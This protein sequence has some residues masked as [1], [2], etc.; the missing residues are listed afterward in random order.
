MDTLGET[1]GYNERQRVYHR[2]HGPPSHAVAPRFADGFLT[3]KMATAH[4]FRR[5]H[6]GTFYGFTKICP[7]LHCKFIL[8]ICI[9]TII[10][11]R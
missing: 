4:V 10:S 5:D 8:F 3:S 9:I 2:N 7:L 11:W 1:F 6:Q